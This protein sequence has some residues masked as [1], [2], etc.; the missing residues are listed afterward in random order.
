MKIPI[1]PPDTY[2]SKAMSLCHCR[3]PM[4]DYAVQEI[5]VG[6]LFWGNIHPDHDIDLQLHCTVMYSKAHH[7]CTWKY[8]KPYFVTA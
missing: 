5:I 8:Q 3:L 7:P 4:C 1:P 2:E 6:M